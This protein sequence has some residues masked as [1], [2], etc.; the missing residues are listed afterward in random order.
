M[1]FRSKQTLTN[2]LQETV[3][4]FMGSEFANRFMND[5]VKKRG[6]TLTTPTG[7]LSPGAQEWQKKIEEEKNKAGQNAT[8]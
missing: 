4:T 8:N 7:N 3:G 6:K 2:H 1:L 5:V